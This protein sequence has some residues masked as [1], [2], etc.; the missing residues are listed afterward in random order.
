VLLFF[1][2]FWR[3]FNLMKGAGKGRI[4]ATHTGAGPAKAGYGLHTLARAGKGRTRATH[5]LGSCG[6]T[7]L[8]MKVT[9]TVLRVVFLAVL[10]TIKEIPSYSLLYIK[11]LYSVLYC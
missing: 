1:V 9:A 3:L 6:L 8:K 7:A 11:E 5:N 2:V 4:R 10:P